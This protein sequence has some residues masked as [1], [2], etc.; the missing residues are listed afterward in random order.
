[1][2]DNG[3]DRWWEF[4]SLDDE[5]TKDHAR[6]YYQLAIQPLEAK[7]QVAVEALERIKEMDYKRSATNFYAYT[8]DSITTEALFKIKGKQ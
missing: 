7:L 2:K 6:D 4:V 8:A 3:F 5:T 1:M